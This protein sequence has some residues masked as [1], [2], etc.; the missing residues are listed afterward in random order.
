LHFRRELQ[1]LV[2]DVVTEG[3]FWVDVCGY[4]PPPATAGAAGKRRY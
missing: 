2:G 1:Y 3:L 4:S